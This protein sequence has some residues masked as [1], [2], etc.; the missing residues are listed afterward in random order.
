MEGVESLKQAGSIIIAH[1]ERFDGQGYPRGLRGAEIPLGARIFA[2]TDTLDAVLSDRPYRS[3]QS[4]EHAR[5]EIARNSGSQFDPEV[6]DCFMRVAP[7][8]WEEIR[9]NSLVRQHSH[10]VLT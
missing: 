1:H 4:Y 5:D 3:G 6:V 10:L 7:R 2:V 9:E 8:N